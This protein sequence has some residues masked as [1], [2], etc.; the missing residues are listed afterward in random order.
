MKSKFDNFD[1]E[2]TELIS[3]LKTNLVK[4]N[5]ITPIEDDKL[6]LMNDVVTTLESEKDLPSTLES[7]KQEINLVEEPIISVAATENVVP[8]KRL[9]DIVIDLNTIRPH[10]EHLPRCILDESGLKIMLNFAKDK[11]LDS[12]AV[13]VITTTNQNSSPVSNFQFEASVSKVCKMQSFM[14]E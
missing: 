6:I 7:Q 1:T 12:I 8:N 9:A 2:I 4:E 10:D 14:N 5:E 13:L 3:G 11:P